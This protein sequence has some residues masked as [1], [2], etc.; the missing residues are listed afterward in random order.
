MRSNPIVIDWGTNDEQELRKHIKTLT[1]FLQFCERDDDGL[2]CWTGDSM[3]AGYGRF[4]HNGRTHFAHRLA[5]A[6][7]ID[8]VPHDMCVCHHNDNPSCVDPNELFLGTDADNL[9]DMHAKGRGITGEA[10]WNA[11]LTSADVLD[12]RRRY[13]GCGIQPSTYALAREYGVGR[14]VIGGVV[15]G[16]TWR[17]LLAVSP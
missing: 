13:K 2:L 3:A 11:K 6:L 10:H 1:R 16:R 4:W 5:Y 8:M 14:S 15:N 9:R 7:F 12:I 17:H